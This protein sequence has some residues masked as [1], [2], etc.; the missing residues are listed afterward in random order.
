MHILFLTDHLGYANGAWHGC[1]TYFANVLPQLLKAGHSVRACVLRTEHPAADHLRANGVEVEFLDR[2]RARPRT[3]WKI[4]RRT[5]RERIDVLHATQ[6]ESSTLVRILKPFLLSTAM[7][8]HVVDSEPLPPMERRLNQYLPQPDAALCVSQYV[9]QT[10]MHEYGVQESRLKVLHNAIDLNA[11]KPSAPDVRERLRREW[12]VPAEAL[13]V[14]SA[15]RLSV[16]KRLDV[17][18]RMIPEVLAS[19]P[20]TVFVLA[21][22]GPESAALQALAHQLGVAHAVRFL[23]HRSDVKDVL[24]ASDVSVMLCLIEA[25]GFSAVE[26]LALGVPVVTY[27]AAGLAEVIAHDRTGLLAPAGDDVQFRQNLLQTLL[28]ADL[29]RRL[30]ASALEDVKRFSVQNHIAALERIY[31]RLLS[32]RTGKDVQLWQPVEQK[33]RRD[34]LHSHDRPA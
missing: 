1:T 15:S 2:A 16:E 28:D 19:A 23:G 14:T 5:R 11:L 6:R 7:V 20:N 26:A 3:L 33:S 21:G 22:D 32:G 25:F 29:R 31:A 24:A 9:C 12:N 13:V 18:I 34:L 27:R 8:T 10:A 30:G 4:A 17:L